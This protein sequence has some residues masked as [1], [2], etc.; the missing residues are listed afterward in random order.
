MMVLMVT[1]HIKSLLQVEIKIKERQHK[2]QMGF[3]LLVVGNMGVGHAI[4]RLKL[5]LVMGSKDI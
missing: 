2:I 3:I 1:K 5:A 4:E